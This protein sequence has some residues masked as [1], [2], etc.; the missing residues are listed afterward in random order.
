MEGVK[1]VLALSSKYGRPEKTQG[2]PA[3]YLTGNAPAPHPRAPGAGEF[4]SIDRE[5]T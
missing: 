5:K 3:Q 2:D 4:C 1:T